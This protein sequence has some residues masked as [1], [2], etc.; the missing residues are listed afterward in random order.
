MNKKT[1][2]SST[3]VK[4]PKRIL[5]LLF[6]FAILFYFVGANYITM[7]ESIHYTIYDRYDLESNVSIDM[8]TLSGEVIIGNR[9]EYSEKCNDACKQLHAFN[10]IIGY[11]TMLLIINFWAMFLGWLAYKKIFRK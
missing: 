7:H 6:I 10:D 9:T 11:N 1:R 3:Q 2:F 5:L 4:F 8:K